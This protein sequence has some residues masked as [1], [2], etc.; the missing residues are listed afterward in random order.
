MFFWCL[1]PFT[2]LSTIATLQSVAANRRTEPK[3]LSA[4]VRGELDWIVMRALETERGRRYGTAS[5]LAD[6]IERF[7]SGE[8]VE[9]YPPST[10]YRLR[11][12]VR[13]NLAQVTVAATF[14]L[15]IICFAVFATFNWYRQ[16]ELYQIAR[17]AQERAEKERATAVEAQTRAEKAQKEA[18]NQQKLSEKRLA[19]LKDMLLDK[20]ITA[21]VSGDL[22]TFRKAIDDASRAGVS[23]VRL[24][25]LRG[26][27][28]MFAGQHEEA[29]SI[30]EKTVAHH[31][32]SATAWAL[33][34]WAYDN[35]GDL[36][37]RLVHCLLWQI[38]NRRTGS[39][40]WSW[41][42]PRCGS[43]LALP[44]MT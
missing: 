43:T 16:A 34:L 36:R 13:R 4:L 37:E 31:G 12:L 39:T 41:G 7:L 24:D 32:N 6:G 28:A 15:L 19:T 3:K 22:Q 27:A 29:I 21:A 35:A 44:W 40:K 11:K 5:G 25:A 8:T 33:L 38:R 20:A 14:G 23:S 1:L 17:T 30:L 9:A 18:Q 26:L 42:A 2:R 10:V